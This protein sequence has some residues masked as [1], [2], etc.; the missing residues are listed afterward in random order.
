MNLQPT[1]DLHRAFW[2]QPPGAAPLIGRPQRDSVFPLHNLQGAL[3]EG[4]LRPDDIRPDDFLPFEPGEAP[5]EDGSDLLNAHWAAPALPWTEAIVGCPVSVLWESGTT[6]AGPVLADAEPLVSY[7]P[8]VDRAWLAKL[9]AC[10]KSLVAHAT[11]RYLVSTSLMRGPLDMLGA[12]LGTARLCQ[13]F[14]DEPEQVARLL[15]FC[16]D[17]WIE[18][19]EAQLA[20]IPSVAGGYANRYRIWAPGRSVV[21]QADISSLISPRIYAR[22]LVPCDAA[23][24]DAF[25]YVTI[26]THSAGQTQLDHWLTQPGLDCI[27]ISVDHLGPTFAEQVPLYRRILER[28]PLVLMNP[29]R[30]EVAMALRELPLAG[31]AMIPRWES[32]L[33]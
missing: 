23:I 14:V 9:V 2:A 26:H 10:T 6:W 33:Q 24:C 15:R 20:V 30:D 5:L 13:A 25:D 29:N 19:A 8:A 4:Y 27:E 31:L 1:F 3:A 32:N 7:R 11:G 18:T 16:T 22:F 17:V 21:T 12:M 28:K